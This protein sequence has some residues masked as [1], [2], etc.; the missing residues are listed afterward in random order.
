[1]TNLLQ[2]LN[3]HFWLKGSSSGDAEC[4][5]NLT[6]GHSQDWLSHAEAEANED[7]WVQIP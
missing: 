2:S 5:T 3:I 7:T 1:M 4:I 6:A